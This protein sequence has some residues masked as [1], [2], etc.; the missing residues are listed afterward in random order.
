[1][2]V[3]GSKLHHRLGKTT[4]Y[5]TLDQVEAMS[6]ATRIAV[7]DAGTIRRIAPPEEIHERPVDLFVASFI[8]S[9]AMA[10]VK[11]K[12]V[13]ADGLKLD[14]T[15]EEGTVLFPIPR[16]L[17]ARAEGFLDREL[18]LGLRPESIVKEGEQRGGRQTFAFERRIDLVEPTGPHTQIIFTLGGIEAMARVHPEDKTPVDSMYRFEVDPERAKLFDPET[19]K[20]LVAV[21]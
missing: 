13:Q 6:L 3:I 16:E 19:G 21:S 8:G 20:R 1:M 5:V 12:V 14:V 15:D 4:I 7:M 2:R 10:L 11:G 9:P 17:T 18:I